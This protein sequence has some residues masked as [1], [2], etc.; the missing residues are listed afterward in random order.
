M[1]KKQGGICP[2]CSKPVTAKEGV[3]HHNDRHAD[4]GKTDDK[5]GILLHPQCHGDV[6]ACTSQ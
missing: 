2:K 4:G 1:E 5:N 3:G 6:H